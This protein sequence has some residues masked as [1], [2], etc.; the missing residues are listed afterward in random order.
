MVLER[1]FTSK[2]ML[3][4]QSMQATGKNGD[5]YGETFKGLFELFGREVK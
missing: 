4:A 2:F 1:F 5:L 3:A